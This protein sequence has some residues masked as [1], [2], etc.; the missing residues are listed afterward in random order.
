MNERDALFS[1]RSIERDDAVLAAAVGEV[2]GLALP[3]PCTPGVAANVRILSGHLA[4]MRAASETP[5]QEQT[6]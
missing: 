1:P 4:T 5:A 2:L 6:R 3:E